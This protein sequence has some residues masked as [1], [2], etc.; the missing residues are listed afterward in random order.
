MLVREP[1]LAKEFRPFLHRWVVREEVFYKWS[2]QS[3]PLLA[4]EDNVV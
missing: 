3:S 4:F 2:R 1:G